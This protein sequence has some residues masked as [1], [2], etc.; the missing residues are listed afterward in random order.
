LGIIEKEYLPIAVSVAR[1]FGGNVAAVLKENEPPVGAHAARKR[2]R[3]RVG[4]LPDKRIYL[5]K[6]RAR[7]NTDDGG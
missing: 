4:N 1:I 7:N 6:G 5:T 3:G 2:L